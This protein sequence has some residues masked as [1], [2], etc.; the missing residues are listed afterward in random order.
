MPKRGE[1]KP[2]AERKPP[3]TTPGRRAAKVEAL[4]YFYQASGIRLPDGLKPEAVDLAE[5]AMARIVDV[6]MERVAPEVA[7]SVL[8]AA[9]RIR[10]EV[11]GPIVQRLEHGGKQGEPININFNWSKPSAEVSERAKDRLIDYIA[12]GLA[13]GSGEHGGAVSVGE[14]DQ[15]GTGADSGGEDSLYGGGERFDSADT[16]EP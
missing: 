1:R 3:T 5:R 2:L 7:P 4:A 15:G 16:R 13:Q 6:A 10:D 11:C 12:P 14:D 9:M 8:K